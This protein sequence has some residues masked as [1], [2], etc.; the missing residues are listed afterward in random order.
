MAAEASKNADELKTTA[1]KQADQ[2]QIKSLSLSLLGI[3][4]P[5]QLSSLS[6]ANSS[7]TD[8][9]AQLIYTKEPNFVL[10]SS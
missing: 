10:H 5:S 4:L 3:I 6:I 8:C 1:L 2:I 9:P 7:A